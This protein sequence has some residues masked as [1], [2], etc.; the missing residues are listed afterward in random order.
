MESENLRHRI[1]DQFSGHG[2]RADIWRGFDLILNTDSFLN[3]GYS[4]WYQPHFL[5][6]SQL[7]LASKIGGHLDSRLEET[8]GA[9][10]VDVGCGRGG[11]AIHLSNQFGFDVTGIDLVPFNV[12]QATHNAREHNANAQFI[13][14]DATAL[15]FDPGLTTACTAIDSLVYV[16]DRPKAISEIAE[17]LT[18]DGIVVISDLLR[19][20]DCNKPD[21]QAVATFADAWDM[22]SLGTDDGYRQMLVEA[23]FSL[24][25][26]EDITPN[27]V[28]R[29]RKWT[30]LFLRLFASPIRPLLDHLLRQCGLDLSAVISQVRAAHHAIPRLKHA[31]YVGRK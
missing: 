10:L 3:L 4:P 5:G 7:R 30:T 20:S 24:H 6:S 31:I 12:A 16:P 21:H 26:V 28:G 18:T 13:V 14:G 1:T 23:G 8:E 25:L 19:R 9:Q 22:P 15:P 2:Q 17:V 29:F 27:S 11:P